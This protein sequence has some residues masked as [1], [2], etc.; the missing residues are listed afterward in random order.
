MDINPTFC[1]APVW[2]NKQVYIIMIEQNWSW[3]QLTL[4]EGRSMG[5]HTWQEVACATCV[6]IANET[7]A[8]EVRHMKGL[9]GLAIGWKI[10]CSVITS[11]S[12]N[13]AVFMQAKSLSYPNPPS[14]FIFSAESLSILT[15]HV[16]ATRIWW[17]DGSVG[18]VAHLTA[19]FSI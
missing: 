18:M 14:F 10:S 3:T 16:H 8:T 5:W 6:Y 13:S 17:T 4:E 19:P 12:E 15:W 2:L 7:G 9:I 11:N 1:T